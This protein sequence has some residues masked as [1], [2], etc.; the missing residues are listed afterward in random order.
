MAEWLCCHFSGIVQILTYHVYAESCELPLASTT[1]TKQLPP[2]PA[3]PTAP[4]H[5]S[6]LSNLAPGH[7]GGEEAGV[8]ESSSVLTP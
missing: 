7:W 5:L 4:L 2:L 8:S 6:V 1:L 3:R